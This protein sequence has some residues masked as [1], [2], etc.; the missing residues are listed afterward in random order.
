ME[1]I[2]L[3]DI[4]KRCRTMNTIRT[5]ELNSTKDL[6]ILQTLYDAYVTVAMENLAGEYTGCEMKYKEF[7][8]KVLNKFEGMS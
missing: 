5:Q 8:D 1:T 2:T 7:Y 3:F 6:A 4:I